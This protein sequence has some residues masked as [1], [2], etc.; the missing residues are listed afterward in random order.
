MEWYGFRFYNSYKGCGNPG[1][2]FE[3]FITIHF[4]VFVLFSNL[5]LVVV[6]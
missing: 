4:P 2:Y 5:S 6:A 3:G 1:V